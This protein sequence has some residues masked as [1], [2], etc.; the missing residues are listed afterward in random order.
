MENTI[1]SAPPSNNNTFPQGSKYSQ[2]PPHDSIS[3]PLQEQAPDYPQ[4]HALGPP[5]HKFTQV[6]TITK[7][8]DLRVY[9]TKTLDNGKTYHRCD[10]PNCTDVE[11][12]PKASQAISHICCVHIKV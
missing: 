8:S 12:S 1:I 9:I 4:E 2:S 11:H 6:D 10:Y 5:P 7:T 3:D